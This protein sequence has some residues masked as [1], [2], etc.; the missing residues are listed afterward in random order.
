MN[1]GPPHRSSALPRQ[2]SPL[3]LPRLSFP[4]RAPD[5]AAGMVGT[6]GS[7]ALGG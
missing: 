7:S 1:L 5:M 3:P 4:V 6:A 2:G